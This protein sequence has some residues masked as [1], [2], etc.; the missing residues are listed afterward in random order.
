MGVSDRSS[1]SPAR[2][3]RHEAI[4]DQKRFGNSL[5]CLDLFP[6]SDGQGRQSYRPSIKAID[7]REQNC[8]I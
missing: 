5:N 4:S 8:A 1:D 3:A 2:S 7:E 6:D